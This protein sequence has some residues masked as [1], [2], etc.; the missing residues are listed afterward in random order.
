MIISNNQASRLKVVTQT[1]ASMLQSSHL[2]AGQ[3][4]TKDCAI[5][6]SIRE[7]QEAI[8]EAFD[9]RNSTRVNVHT[10]II[11]D[12]G[13]GRFET[14]LLDLSS[15]GAFLESVMPFPSGTPLTLRFKIDSGEITVPAE[16]A[17]SIQHVGFGVRFV[18]LREQD[19]KRLD[20]FLQ[21]KRR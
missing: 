15:T 5:C 16:V 4:D 14:D 3:H 18:D 11:G 10:R 17:Y 12:T 1:L 9:R 6:K 8:A 2:S 7:S 13:I 19:R 20:S 21:A